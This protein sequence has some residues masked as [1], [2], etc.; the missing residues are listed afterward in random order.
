MLRKKKQSLQV[1]SYRLVKLTN[2]MRLLKVRNDSEDQIDL[3]S[4]DQMLNKSSRYVCHKQQSKIW[5]LCNQDFE[6]DIDN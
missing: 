1:L 5:V 2:L 4:L 3:S 6:D